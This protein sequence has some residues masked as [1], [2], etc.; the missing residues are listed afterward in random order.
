MIYNDIEFFEV[1]GFTGYYIS[2]CG[3]LLST[4]Y[5]TKIRSAHK[6]TFGY[7]T[8]RLFENGKATLCQQHRLLA[9]TFIPNPLNKE[10]VN[11]INGI[12]DD[13]RLD[14]LEWVS[15][16]ENTDHAKAIG[17]RRKTAINRKITFEKAQEVKEMCKDGMKLQ[18]IADLVG[19]HKTSVHNITSN[20]TYK[21][22]E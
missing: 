16:Q 4:K 6:N 20:R 5:Q 22:K 15:H 21:V 1:T 18:D 10:Q 12:K 3:Q 8:Y 11:H 14:N 7:M 13:N 9:L 2:K 17:L 19:L